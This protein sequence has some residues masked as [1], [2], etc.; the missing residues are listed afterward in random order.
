MS[1]GHGKFVSYSVNA[2]QKN[3]K[4][5]TITSNVATILR[6][7]AFQP[8]VRPTIKAAAAQEAKAKKLVP[9][10]PFS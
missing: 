7:T 1:A 5:A 9:H 10:L 3:A 6:T 2:A 8:Q 4:S